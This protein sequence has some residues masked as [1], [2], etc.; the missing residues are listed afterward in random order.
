MSNYR[1]I[2]FSLLLVF[3]SLWTGQVQ[4]APTIRRQAALQVVAAAD[5][6]DAAHMLYSDT[7]ALRN[8]L[9]TLDRPVRRHRYR[10]ALA[11]A[12]YYMGRNMSLNSDYARAADC[13]IACDRLHPDDPIRRGRVNACM[14]YICT[15]HG[16][17]SLALVFNQRSLEAFR[18]SNNIW[19]YAHK[20]LFLSEN[21]CKLGEYHIADSLWQ[22]AS[23][24]QIDST[25][26][27]YV[28]ETRGLNFYYRQQYDSALTCFLQIED[29]PRSNQSKCY[30]YMKIVQIYESLGK[31]AL[32]Y[33]Y[34]DYIL[35]YSTNP[36]QISNAYYTLINYAEQI[37]DAALVATYSHNREDAGR[38]KRALSNRNSAAVEKCRQYLANPYP[39]RKWH[40]VVGVAVLLCG[41]LGTAILLLRYRKRKDIKQKD[42]LIRQQHL[43]LREKD[44][45]IQQQCIQAEELS[46]QL[47]VQ[48]TT[49]QQTRMYLQHAEQQL[50]QQTDALQ[51]LARMVHTS[52][53][54]EVI[55]QLEH[56][57]IRYPQPDKSWN[58]YLVLKKDI[59]HTLLGV[60]KQLEQKSLSHR[61][62]TV[63]ICSLIYK[64]LTLADLAQY[65]CYSQNSIRTTRTRIAK[66]LGIDS[67]AR[68]HEYLMDL[69]VYG[70][71]VHH[72][73]STCIHQEITIR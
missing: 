69:A 48:K 40:I 55:L 4:A 23:A 59:G 52:R 22:E 63:C 18:N 36:T 44:M 11:A 43:L 2:Y 31:S 21:Y 67:A 24:F 61:E 60:C 14:A 35:R 51:D 30:D 49:L 20:L 58:T 72:H 73:S 41:I 17:D 32:A 5:S 33:P 6:M 45:Q 8:A 65:L 53:E 71:D 12:Y 39:N 10:N 25:Y 46:A 38:E 42:T 70:T 16:E 68:L 19:Y 9:R 56:L 47:Q 1:H 62:I 13:Y 50:Q 57:R 28:L 26:R 7:A 15:Q 54:P 66:K 64:S 37:D 3:L 29:Y 27:F 34:A